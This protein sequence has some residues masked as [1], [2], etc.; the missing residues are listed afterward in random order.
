MQTQTNIEDNSSI[1]IT[2]C[3][4]VIVSLDVFRHMTK[5]L[6][7]ETLITFQI[8]DGNTDNE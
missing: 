5:E 2:N 4:N 6:S 1:N 7:P 3:G 8:F